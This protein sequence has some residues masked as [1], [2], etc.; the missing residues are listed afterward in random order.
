MLLK[1]LDG[2]LYIQAKNPAWNI[3]S[4][5]EGQIRYQVDGR[6]Y[7]GLQKTIALAEAPGRGILGAL[8]S[9]M[10]QQ[11]RAGMNLAIVNGGVLIDQ[12][13]LKGTQA[14]LATV[15]SCLAD[16]RANP[17]K[18][19]A[20]AITVRAKPKN[21][22]ARWV[23]FRDYNKLGKREGGSGMVGFRLQIGVKGRVK[24]CEIS[25]SSGYD[26]IDKATC[27][28]VSKRARFHPAKNSKGQSVPD[29]YSSRVRLQLP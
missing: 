14:A 24:G 21:D 29:S 9:D 13:S 7:N 18:P 25:R 23:G 15:D 5:T 2:A 16:L 27:K 3:K 8:G 26:D 4:G 22:P 1:R 12:L 10:E 28:A 20:P 11:I 17:P 6:T 19:A